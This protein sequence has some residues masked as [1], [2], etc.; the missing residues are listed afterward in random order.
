[1]HLAAIKAL[2]GPDLEVSHV[3]SHSNL[4]GPHL[5]VFNN[6][7]RKMK[8]I[9]DDLP[10]LQ[11]A[12]AVLASKQK[13]NAGGNRCIDVGFASDVNMRPFKSQ[14]MRKESVRKESRWRKMQ[15]KGL[16]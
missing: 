9:V 7:K 14:G 4:E 12:D 5:N 6:L 2:N 16:L 10:L 1:L 3:K 15:A 8:E 13:D 11:L